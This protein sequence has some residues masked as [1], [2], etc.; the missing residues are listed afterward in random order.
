MRYAS[1]LL[2]AGLLA[3]PCPAGAELPPSV[4]TDMQGSAPEAIEIRVEKVDVSI[5]W[6]GLCDGQDVVVQA[7]VKAVTRSA[8]GLKPGARIEIR[9]R[10]VSLGQSSGPRP[11][12]IVEAGETTPAFLARAEGHYRAAARGAS[13][14]PPDAP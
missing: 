4:Y 8:T 12:R 1:L 9:Y 5:C 11:I 13:F 10:H 3:L 6:F 7:E 2:L 14:D